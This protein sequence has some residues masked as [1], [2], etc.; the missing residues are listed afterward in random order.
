MSSIR[1][2]YNRY[3]V[4]RA[5]RERGEE[6]V[7]DSSRNSKDMGWNTMQNVQHYS[8]VLPICGSVGDHTATLT[9]KL[10]S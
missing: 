3:H 9:A 1:R 8:R 6:Q 10:C 7:S 4:L 5:S 2:Q